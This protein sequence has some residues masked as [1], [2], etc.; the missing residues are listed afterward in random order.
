MSIEYTTLQGKRSEVVVDDVW[1]DGEE[2]IYAGADQRT[3]QRVTIRR[4]PI[5]WVQI[6]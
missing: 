1:P 4:G 3:G 6:E 5:H 2:R